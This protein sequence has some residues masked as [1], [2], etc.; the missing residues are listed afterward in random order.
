MANEFTLADYEATAPD[1]LQKAMVRTWRE[2]SPI[3]D[4]LKFKTSNRLSEKILRFGSLPTVPWR[5]IGESYTQVK[6]TPD[7]VEERLYFMGAKIDIAKEYV[8]ADSLINQR[9]VQEEAVLKGMAYGFNEAFFINTPLVDE[10]A[11]VGLWYRL[12]NDMPSAQS[13]DGAG[14]DISPDTSTT[15]V[16]H[17]FFD[18][19]DALLATVEGNPA[20]KVLFMNYTL[21]K[22]AQSLMRQSLLLDTTTDQIGRQF[23]TYGK[24]G[25]KIVDVGYKV[26]Q[27]TMV[28]PDTELA[29]GTA[30]TGATFSSIFCVR[31]G[32][33]YLSGWA[34]TTPSAE[35]VGLLEDRVN[36][37]TVV[38]FAPGLIIQHPRAIARAYD[39]QAV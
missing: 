12:I 1:P 3:L 32:E 30:L 5:K 24:G 35:D 39:I 33:P 19:L 37:R 28:L 15:N 17:K 10:D 13:V 29:N 31:F 4:M 21:W 20:D 8:K 6:I 18:L 34:M 2:V 25:P 11:V 26:D 16:A 9:K 14:L 22:R 7:T 27:S 38:D 23:M 36:Y